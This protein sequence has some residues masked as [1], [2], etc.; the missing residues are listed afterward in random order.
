[1]DFFLLLRQIDSDSGIGDCGAGGGDFGSDNN[2]FGDMTV[3]SC[4][5][6]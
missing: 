6:P 2:Q 1:M 3:E 4:N 5:G